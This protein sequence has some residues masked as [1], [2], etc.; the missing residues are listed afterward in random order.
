MSAHATAGA[1]A[2]CPG[3]TGTNT[4][5][6]LRSSHQYSIINDGDNDVTITIVARLSDS[7][8]NQNSETRNN[9]VVPAKGSE[10]NS[11]Q[12]FLTAAYS[13]SGTIHVTA[14]T[15]ITGGASASSQGN[16]SF[17]VVG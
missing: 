3:T 7:R 14:S 4:N 9:V 11:L 2:Q 5:V 10:S 12:V 17:Q 6:T 13:P 15:I 1:S 16:C 8:G